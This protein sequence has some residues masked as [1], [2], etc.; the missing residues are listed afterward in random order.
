MTLTRGREGQVRRWTA[1]AA[2]ALGLAGPSCAAGL[3]ITSANGYGRLIFSNEHPEA[4]VEDSV[5]V[6]QFAHRPPF[7]A[8]E[9]MRRLPRYISD[10]HAGP[11][12]KTFRFALI[13]PVWLHQSSSGD[14]FAVDLVPA[15]Y[16]GTPP[17]LPPPPPVTPKPVNIATLPVLPI[18]AGAYAHF[19]RLLFVLKSPITYSIFPGSGRITL[20]FD[21]KLRPDFTAL[22]TVAPPWVKA[23]GWHVDS[24]GTV[25]SFNTLA[26]SGYHSFRSGDDVVL[27]ILAPRS[28]SQSY[29]PPGVKGAAA[30]G[31]IHWLTSDPKHGAAKAV[32]Q[33]QAVLNAVAAIDG[34][35][36]RKVV[37]PL[38]TPR[39][40]RAKDAAT[41]SSSLPVTA[42]AS[43]ATLSFPAGTAIAAFMREGNAWIVLS[44][45]KPL[46]VSFLTKALGGFS[47]AVTVSSQAGV[48]VVRIALRQAEQIR[49]TSDGAANVVRI[50]PSFAST[51]VAR[52]LTITRDIDTP[53]VAALR[54]ALPGAQVPLQLNDPV[55]GD[56]LIVVPATPGRVLTH[57]DRYVD[58]AALPSASGLVISPY[59]E[60]LDVRSSGDH[61]RISRPGGL[62]LTAGAIP[63]VANPATLAEITNGPSYLN[64]AAWAHPMHLDVLET[65]RA[66]RDAAAALP[67]AQANGARRQ[68]AQFYVANR[69]DAE[70]LGVVAQMQSSDPTL[71]DDPE[72]Q[73]IKA[74]ADVMMA[75]YRDARS[76]LS[77]TAFANDPHAA[78]W[79]GLADAGLRRW[80]EARHAL[81]LAMS[82]IGRYP[83][84]WQARVRLAYAHAAIATRALGVAKKVLAGIPKG[85][86][87]PL[88][89]EAELAQARI[90]VAEGRYRA[91][92]PVLAALKQC[93]DPKVAAHAIYDDAL[94]ALAA[95]AISQSQAIASLERL[96]Y[97][98]RGDA[99]EL[100][101]LRKLGSLYF[102]QKKW[103]KGLGVLQVA[104]ESFPNDESTRHVQD[105]MRKAFIALF[106][107]GKA[108]KMPP[109]QALGLFYDYIDL[110]PIGADGDAMIRRMANRLVDIDLLG[111]AE[112]LL[113]YQVDKR[114]NGVAQAQVAGRL[115]MVYL[116]DHKARHA[117]AVLRATR[118]AGMPDDVAHARLL[119]EARALAA[120][121]QYT[122]AL[123]LIAVEKGADTQRLRADIYWESGNWPLAGRE[124][125][126]LLGDAWSTKGALSKVQRRYVMRA[127]IAYS[128]AGDAA[129]LSRL[130]SHFAQQMAQ[131]PDAA[132]FAVVTQNVST[133]G[134]AFRDVA[135]K[136]ASIDTL[137]SFMK[138]FKKSFD[139]IPSVQ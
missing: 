129:S 89:Y 41:L 59:A 124:A 48:G 21:A 102:A 20:H 72:L 47:N 121:K 2:F 45:A 94:S 63:A 54:V 50:A 25:I 19:S 100:Q 87:P 95:G 110:T 81:M 42:N 78:I 52:P 98:W 23:A 119:L 93:P 66:L 46:Q 104:V 139:A 126:A 26:G 101:T 103:R 51:S 11:R 6:L 70:A 112:K 128:L 106:L 18:R 7:T 27:D 125:E 58:F 74:A 69:L 134:V 24:T 82:V 53:D 64:F 14:L 28:D 97:R 34:K 57:A 5:F 133:Q 40:H 55:A 117:L 130:R 10:A 60:G 37:V 29:D 56:T 88:S 111:P 3:T 36:A 77:A 90:A 13:N 105:D 71:Q 75:R 16:T 12:G 4:K 115:A 114:L 109:I 9:I 92:A 73:T 80:P 61:V 31:K 99:L 33:R 120:L 38:P 49:V 30:R 83:P 118:V 67:S 91:A 39:P 17:D 135:A 1:I 35:T 84:N 138:D 123:D 79:R 132:S 65:E 136:V 137:E 15:N 131:G 22:E 108:D 68:E 122:Q 62:R 116:M 113:K 32:S 85:L 8:K 107:H 86:R 44:S 96:R 76:A 127:A 43:S